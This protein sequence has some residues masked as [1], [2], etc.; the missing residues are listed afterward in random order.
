MQSSLAFFSNISSAWYFS[1]HV[2][3]MGDE[4]VKLSN[5]GVFK[6]F[7]DAEESKCYKDSEGNTKK[8]RKNQKVIKD[9]PDAVQGASGGLHVPTDT[10]LFRAPLP[11]AQ[12]IWNANEGIDKYTEFSQTETEYT[13]FEELSK[14]VIEYDDFDKKR[15]IG[16]ERD[17][18]AEVQMVSRAWD[19]ANN[20]EVYNTRAAVKCIRDSVNDLDNLNCTLGVV[21]MKKQSAVRMSLSDYENGNGLRQ[22]LLYYGVRPNTTRRICTTFEESANKIADKVQEQGSDVYDR[23]ADEMISMIGYMKLD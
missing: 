5:G 21:N 22:N 4:Y 14:V 8:V 6:I 19:R 17:Y 18:I 23:F 16:V 10:E 13:T 7:L 11:S 20:G 15:A 1:F 12:E 3:S 9:P 2:A